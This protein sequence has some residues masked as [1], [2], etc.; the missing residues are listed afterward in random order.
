MRKCARFSLESDA[1]LHCELVTVA[2]NIVLLLAEVV[3]KEST[4]ARSKKTT[5]GALQLSER[6]SVCAPSV[7]GAK[8][9]AREYLL[10]LYLFVEH[11]VSLF[12]VLSTDGQDHLRPVV[13]SPSLTVHIKMF[14]C[15]R[16]VGREDGWP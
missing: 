16:I 11:V 1:C 3:R 9:T 13:A 10:Q 15:S 8:S 14:A 12:A 6:R 5:I 4:V 7:S 2:Q